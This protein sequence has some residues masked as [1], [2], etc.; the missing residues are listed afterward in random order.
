MK[1]GR[2]HQIRIHF[3]N[4]GYVLVGDSVPRPQGRRSPSRSRVRRSTPGTSGGRPRKAR[5][6]R[7]TRDPSGD[8]LKLLDDLRKSGQERRSKRKEQRRFLEKNT[9]F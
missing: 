9:P 8:F 6:S 7:W 1:T 5:R 4:A 3:A 2:T